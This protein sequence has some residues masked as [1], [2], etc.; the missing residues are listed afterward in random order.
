MSII[1]SI[2]RLER[3]VPAEGGP[4]LGMELLDVLL[5]A[6]QDAAIGTE[7]LGYSEVLSGPLLGGDPVTP[8]QRRCIDARARQIV[9]DTVARFARG[10]P[11]VP[12]HCLYRNRCPRR[13]ARARS[14]VSPHGAR[15]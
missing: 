13:V 7:M 10:E 2:L 9:D 12:P 14:T 11:S 8:A 1:A 5:L 3:L 15:L 6:M 4:Y